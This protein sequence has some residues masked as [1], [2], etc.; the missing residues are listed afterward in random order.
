[1]LFSSEKQVATRYLMEPVRSLFSFPWPQVYNED[2]QHPSSY[3]VWA[4]R[5]RLEPFDLH[6]SML[7]C[8]QCCRYSLISQ[9]SSLGEVVYMHP[10]VAHAYMNKW[11]CLNTNIIMETELTQLAKPK[12]EWAKGVTCLQWMSAFPR[13]HI[14]MYNKQD[15]TSAQF[16]IRV[17]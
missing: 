9:V 5:R 15:W 8:T 10:N 7:T 12:S 11:D 6:L 4:I 14:Q 1:M 16:N 2:N 17:S 3:R 13:N